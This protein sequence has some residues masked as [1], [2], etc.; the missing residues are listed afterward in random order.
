MQISPQRSQIDTTRVARRGA[1]SGVGF[2]DLM[3]PPM[4]DRNGAAGVTS[5][6]KRQKYLTSGR[7][8]R[9][10]EPLYVRRSYVRRAGGMPGLDG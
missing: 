6:A 1:G 5:G 8:A 10:S 9:F 4:K 3:T 2:V 7:D